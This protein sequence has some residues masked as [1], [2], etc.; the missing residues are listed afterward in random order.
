[1][2]MDN[3]DEAAVGAGA[4]GRGYL[5][6]QPELTVHEHG[7]FARHPQPWSARGAPPRQGSA[8]HGPRVSW[9]PGRWSSADSDRLTPARSGGR[10]RRLSPGP[11]ARGDPSGQRSPA[12]RTG[13]R[14]CDRP[15]GQD[16]RGPRRCGLRQR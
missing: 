4:Y 10:Q 9:P 3:H 12:A 11:I 7:C 6:P 5:A 14:R 15:A 13:V 8:R 2:N 1:M 16:A